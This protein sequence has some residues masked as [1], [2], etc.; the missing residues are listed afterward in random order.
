M[1]LT[2][3]FRLP[4]S[5]AADFVR[6]TTPCFD[7]LKELSPAILNTAYELTYTQQNP[8]TLSAKGYWLH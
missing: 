5:L 6:P 1:Q 4:T 3:I 7:A 8:T 2:R